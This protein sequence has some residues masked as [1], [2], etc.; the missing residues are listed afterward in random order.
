MTA[1]IAD[2]WLPLFFLPE[3]VRDVFG[4]ALDAGAAALA[5]DLGPAGGC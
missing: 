1:E 3:R 2:G 4:A 5:D